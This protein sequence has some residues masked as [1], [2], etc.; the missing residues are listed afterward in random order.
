[1]GNYLIYP[2]K[3]I[4]FIDVKEMAIELPTQR[5]AKTLIFGAF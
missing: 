1:M 4:D 2:I 5:R 3:A